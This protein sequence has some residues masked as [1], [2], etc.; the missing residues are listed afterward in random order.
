[1]T[2][3]NVA[4]LRLAG[5]LLLFAGAFVVGPAQADWVLPTGANV[6]LGGGSVRLGCTDL[7]LDG[8]LSLSGGSVGAA[9]N[10]QVTAG[11]QLDVGAGTVD[12]A[13]QWSNQGSVSVTTGGVTR[14]ASA[15][16]PVVG[17]AGP[18]QLS[19]PVPVTV[20]IPGSSG[21]TAQVL[22]SGTGSCTVVPG[23]VQISNSAPALPA[24]AATPLGVLRFN[25]AGCT[26][27]SVTVQVTYPVGS[28]SGLTVRKYGPFGPQPAPAGWFSPP[29]LSVSS[30]SGGDVVTYTV[31]DNGDGDSN[32]NVGEISDPM[33]PMLLGAV[34]P[35]PGNVQAV[36]TLGQWGVLVLV[37]LMGVLGVRRLRPLSSRRAA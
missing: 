35:T 4:G 2:L 10:V 34:A 28:L 20:S 1:M 11:A 13:Q 18:V 15:G 17:S 14:V 16:C 3:F 5:P 7:Q 21:G 23:S 6:Q 25:A 31:S 19:A 24:N 32:S 30:G 8:V 22:V 33:A 12:L 36:P 29:G 26:G 37:G 9:R 27:A